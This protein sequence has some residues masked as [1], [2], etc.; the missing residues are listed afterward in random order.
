MRTP[1][2]TILVSLSLVATGLLL[3]LIFGLYKIRT[4]SAE[5]VAFENQAESLGQMD[6]IAQTVRS[7]KNNYGVDLSKVDNLIVSQKK[8]VAFIEMIE[9]LGGEIGLKTHTLS[10]NTDEATVRIALET[11][12]LW[13]RS[14]DFIQTLE[15][16]PYKVILD[17]TTM[18]YNVELKEWHTTIIIVLPFF[19]N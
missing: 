2:K 1:T 19:D 6:N 18:A 7:I 8:V 9:G 5:V 11:D 17:E 10:V 15:N 14:M 4:Q 16:L 3:I 13:A 12:G